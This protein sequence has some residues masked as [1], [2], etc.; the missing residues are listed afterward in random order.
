MSEVWGI[1][2]SEAQRVE[3]GL[4]NRFN[5]QAEEWS[6]GHKQLRRVREGHSN[7]YPC[8]RI[9]VWLAKSTG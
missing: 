8:F 7:R 3:C 6:T 4:G 1:G 2:G 9:T 5:R